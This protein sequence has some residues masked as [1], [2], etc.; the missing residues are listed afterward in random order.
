MMVWPRLVKDSPRAAAQAAA[1]GMVP[2]RNDLACS[3][4]DL[5]SAAGRLRPRRRPAPHGAPATPAE[6]G[7]G[8]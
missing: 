8:A 5:Q 4:R 3:S 1:R 2:R 7:A 6:T